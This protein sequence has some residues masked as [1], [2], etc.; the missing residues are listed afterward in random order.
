[1]FNRRNL[2]QSALSSF[3]SLPFLKPAD[4][5]VT[6][7]LGETTYFSR[8]GKVFKEVEKFDGCCHIKQYN[9]LGEMHG[10]QHYEDENGISTEYY[11]NGNLHNDTGPAIQYVSEDGKLLSQ[12]WYVDGVCHRIGGPAV[13]G[14]THNSYVTNGIQREYISYT[15]STKS[16][17]C[18][19]SKYNENGNL[20]FHESNGVRTYLK[21]GKVIRR[22]M[23]RKAK[24]LHK[25]EKAAERK[26][27]AYRELGLSDGEPAADWAYDV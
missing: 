24:K 22:Q 7:V 20:I 11:V 15:D 14:E 2:I 17:I 13:I 25:A 6:T 12:E 18:Y 21:S 9:E 23:T 1:M 4:E 26:L 27:K 3:F 19:H 5:V 10:V 8:A 16:E